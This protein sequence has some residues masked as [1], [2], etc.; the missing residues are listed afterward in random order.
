MEK[1]TRKQVDEFCKNFAY[2]FISTECMLKEFGNITCKDAQNIKI[3]LEN[4]MSIDLH[5]WLFIKD[6]ADS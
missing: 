2:K 4:T 1:L 3:H 6:I 5:D